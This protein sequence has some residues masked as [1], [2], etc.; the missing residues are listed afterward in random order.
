M[1]RVVSPVSRM[2]RTMMSPQMARIVPLAIGSRMRTLSVQR[3]SST[4]SQSC[5]ACSRGT[6][7]LLKAITAG[8]R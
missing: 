3:G 2:L 7:R 8:V 1:A 6:T 4:S 5:G